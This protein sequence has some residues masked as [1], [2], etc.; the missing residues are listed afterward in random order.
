MMF[1]SHSEWVNNFESILFEY[2]TKYIGDDVD[3]V[4]WV[5]QVIKRNYK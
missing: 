3:N 4:I 5:S 1:D 2:V